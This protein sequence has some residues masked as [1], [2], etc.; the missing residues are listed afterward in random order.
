MPTAPAFS[1]DRRKKAPTEDKQKADATT[2][3]T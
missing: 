2:V 3:P 1:P